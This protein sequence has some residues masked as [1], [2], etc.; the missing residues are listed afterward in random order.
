M[1]MYIYIIHVLYGAIRTKFKCN[2][3]Y[4][5]LDLICT[6]IHNT[7]GFLFAF[8]FESDSDFFRGSFTQEV[9]LC[10]LVTAR[11]TRKNP[12]LDVYSIL[13]SRNQILLSTRLITDWSN[14]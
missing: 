8:G 9:M 13:P 6:S 5:C 14:R 7:V 4:N 11:F 3:N 1:C 2:S 12:S 10:M